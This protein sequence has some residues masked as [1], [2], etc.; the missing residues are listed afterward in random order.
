M[1]VLGRSNCLRPSFEHF[2]VILSDT[3]FQ[4]R[5]VFGIHL[6]QDL[7][8]FHRINKR[9]V[10]SFTTK[11]SHGM[12]RITHENDPSS[13]QTVQLE[14]PPDMLL[15]LDSTDGRQ[16]EYLSKLGRQ[17]RHA[18]ENIVQLF[19]L[20]GRP[21]PVGRFCNMGVRLHHHPVV[22]TRDTI[23]EGMVQAAKVPE[24]EI[25]THVDV[26][27]VA[28]I[29]LAFEGLAGQGQ[30]ANDGS[31]RDEIEDLAAGLLKEMFSYCQVMLI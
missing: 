1:D 27:A 7:S 31:K 3:G 24:P 22:T 23:G 20:G 6:A 4:S 12:R 21:Q 26:H 14:I 28:Q 9:M 2:S 18:V 5:E 8:Q 11:G 19:L 10:A 25:W 29:K 16:L 30:L 15:F 13:R 17:L